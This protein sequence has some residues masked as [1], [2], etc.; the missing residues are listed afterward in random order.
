MM[1]FSRFSGCMWQF[2]VCLCTLL[3]PLRLQSCVLGVV[4]LGIIIVVPLSHKRPD[5]VVFLS[6]QVATSGQRS[7]LYSKKRPITTDFPFVMCMTLFRSYL[8][9][10]WRLFLIHQMPFFLT[11][12]PGRLGIH[13]GVPIS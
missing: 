4:S 8:C 6:L 7:R 11:S 12:L 5:V 3:L 10:L 2:F 13:I 9:L 1:V